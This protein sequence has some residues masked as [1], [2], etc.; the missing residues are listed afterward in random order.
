MRKYVL[1]V[2]AAMIISL[3]TFAANEITAN[4]TMKVTKGNLDITR[5]SASQY[6]LVAA[7]PNVA[8]LT[9]NITTNAAGEAI[10]LGD[11][12]TN[13]VAWFRNLNT[14]QTFYVEIGVTNQDATFAPVIRLNAN[15]VWPVRM[16]QG[17]VPYARATTTGTTATVVIEKLIF[18]N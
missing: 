2:C 18:D 12:T 4:F 8:G 9:Q 3:V 7:N 17:I 1:P 10:T 11:V 13:G 16:A 6:T 5:V 15:E 14:N